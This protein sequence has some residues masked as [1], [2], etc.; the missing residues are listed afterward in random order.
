MSMSPMM[1]KK[2]KGYSAFST[3]NPQQATLLQQLLGSMTGQ[4]ANIQQNPLYQSG[5][6]Y[7]QKIL[8]GDTSE[9]EAPLMR[10]FNEQIIPGIAERFSGL[11]SG[12]QSSSAFQQALGGAGADLSERLGA[13]RGGLQM[14]AVPQALGYA[15][16][17]FTNLQN[18]LGIKTQG[19]LPKQKSGLQ[20]GIIA[21]SQTL[22][23]L[24][25]LLFML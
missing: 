2:P 11:G 14:Q 20:E 6:N 25:P 12:A 18:L 7:L 15:Q 16:Q 9:F 8:S 10:Q 23:Q 4:S 21:G 17:P 5:G 3:L 24:L 13:L 22:M 19:F 1:G